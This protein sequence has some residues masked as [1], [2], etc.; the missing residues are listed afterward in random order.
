M[1]ITNIL[2]K[3]HCSGIAIVQAIKGKFRCKFISKFFGSGFL[4]Y[5]MTMA[6]AVVTLRQNK[7]IAI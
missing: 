2:E 7:K 5:H 1:K 3:L 4:R 6:E